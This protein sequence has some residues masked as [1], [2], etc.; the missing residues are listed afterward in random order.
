MTKAAVLPRG[1]V[2]VGVDGTA[3]DE[4]PIRVAI[5]QSRR[6]GRPLHVLHA[7]AIGIVP[8]TPERLDKQRSIT[9][10]CLAHA[11]ALD[12]HLELSSSTVVDDQSA[13]LVAATESASVVVMGA[14]RL[15]RVGSVVLGAT[16]GKVV[17][18]AQCPV[19]V[20]P[21]SWR[22]GDT[23]P[24]DAR[25][26]VVAVDDD[27]HSL[28]ALEWGFAEAAARNAPLVALHA[29]W[30]EEPT[31]LT[32]ALA[33][34]DEWKAAAESQ[35]VMM[36]E[37]LAGWREKFP[38]VDVQTEFVR[39]ETTAV[40]EEAS[41]DAQLLVLGTRGRGGFAG[42]LLGSVSARAL[43]HSHCPV[44][45]VPSRPDLGKGSGPEPVRGHE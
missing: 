19:L 7:T 9:A 41:D 13:A 26:V 28:S 44:V 16:T 45:V 11:R 21:D 43:H 17:S 29:W 4:V 12:P 36:G 5:A 20:V 32:A 25:P 23:A 35:R 27:V 18:H 10:A 38:D 2:V 40:L 39:G 3:N 22:A 30:W 31:P 15:G 42:L 34:D 1:G 33:G 6:H 24:G 37:M 14:G 8:W